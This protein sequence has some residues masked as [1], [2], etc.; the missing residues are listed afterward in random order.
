MLEERLSKSDELYESELLAYKQRLL[1]DYLGRFVDETATE[2][3]EKG[4]FL[5][6]IWNLLVKIFE[7]L[8]ERLVAEG[9]RRENQFLREELATHSSYQTKLE[10]YQALNAELKQSDDKYQN[11]VRELMTNIA[12][13]N[14]E[15]KGQRALFDR[16]ASSLTELSQKYGEL[17]SEYLEIL[18]NG[19]SETMT[20]ERAETHLTDKELLLFTRQLTTG[21]HGLRAKK[22]RDRR[23]RI[24][25][26]EIDVG[27]LLEELEAEDDYSFQLDAGDRK[28]VTFANQRTQTA[29]VGYQGENMGA[30]CDYVTRSE[31]GQ[32]R[33]R[34]AQT[35]PPPKLI[36][37]E[38]Q[39]QTN[40]ADLLCRKLEIGRCFS[41]TQYPFRL[42]PRESIKL[43]RNSSKEYV[44]EVL[45]R[46]L[47]QMEDAATCVSFQ[48][49]K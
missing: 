1:V 6:A 34:S 14:A 35:N 5:K 41:Y 46:K 43:L 9:K 11:I 19:F 24:V 18:V 8:C 7:G 15:L 48:T 31:E 10:E 26:N 25:N 22:G 32:L 29:F 16:T 21:N 30:Q 3:V 28:E 42:E 12:K 2:C 36:Q 44:G 38:A 49:I 4:Q 47:P 45:S 33:N 17:R 37:R 13:L 39:D 27:L 23:E 40:P 20:R